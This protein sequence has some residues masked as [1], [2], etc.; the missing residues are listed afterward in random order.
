MK[1]PIITL[2][3]A[4]L[5]SSSI[6]AQQLTEAQKAEAI[7]A[8]KNFCSLLSQFSNGGTQYLTND[9]KIFALCSS[10]KISTYDNISSHKEIMLNAYLALITRNYHNRLPMTFSTPIIEEIYYMPKFDAWEPIG[11]S[12][13]NM[14]N[15]ISH[16]GY[17]DIWIT[18]STTQ[19]IPKMSE[20][21]KRY[22][23]YNPLN[24]NI[25]SFTA[26]KD[27]P[28]A[29]LHKALMSLSSNKFTETMDICDKV[30]LYPRFDSKYQCA[31]SGVV[32][33]LMGKDYRRGRT[34]CKYLGEYEEGSN[35]FFHS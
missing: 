33:A 18:L 26:T 28:Y 12:D 5:C 17:S 34:Y 7:N 32:A 21:S 10:P 23:I 2:L 16:S 8:V 20:S 6:I 31:C 1:R 13:G 27:S 35:L 25:L 9:K 14:S 4:L 29:L 11:Q 24:R 15:L 30:L 3:L 22:F 19:S